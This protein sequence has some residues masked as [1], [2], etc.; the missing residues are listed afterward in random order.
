MIPLVK[1]HKYHLHLY[2]FVLE[3][4]LVKKSMEINP[5][6]LEA[7][8]NPIY[9]TEYSSYEA[10]WIIDLYEESNNLYQAFSQ[11]FQQMEKDY[12]KLIGESVRIE[13]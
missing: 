11:V 5:R 13:K 4:E 7:P 9:S 12:S 3:R 1:W 10:A 8:N 6:I 2:I